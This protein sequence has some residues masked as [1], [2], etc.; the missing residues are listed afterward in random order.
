MDVI[1]PRDCYE[2]LIERRVEKEVDAE[3]FAALEE[4]E[5]FSAGWVVSAVVLDETGRVLLTYHGGDSAW[6][7]PG[8]SVQPSESLREA[9]IRE[10]HEETEVSITPDRPHAIVEN[11]VR[12]NGKSLS[13]RFVMFSAWAESTEVGDELGEPGEP[14]EEAD[15][16][17]DLPADVFEEP[18][19]E[20][21]LQRL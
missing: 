21:V 1:D 16:F 2:D 10:V 8:G 12:H 3:A 11:I 4:N 17:D 19:V 20:R 15:W 7:A 5:A 6:L 14:I 9:V 18:L 13:F